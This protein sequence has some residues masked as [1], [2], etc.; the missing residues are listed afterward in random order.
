MPMYWLLD[1]EYVNI[2]RNRLYVSSVK[3][4]TRG[5]HVDQL[6]GNKNV[7][8]ARNK[9]KILHKERQLHYCTNKWLL[10]KRNANVSM[11]SALSGEVN[12]DLPLT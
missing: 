4:E 3:Q 5:N 10:L 9:F 6:E 11:R 12:R 1:S 2:N 8:N 7:L